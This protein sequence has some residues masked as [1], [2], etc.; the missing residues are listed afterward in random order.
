MKY[1]YIGTS[2]R[3]VKTSEKE[4]LLTGG[5]T[6]ETIDVIKHPLIV[7]YVERKSGGKYNVKTTHK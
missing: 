4:L 7:L 5:E 6:F 1:K 3:T 2:P